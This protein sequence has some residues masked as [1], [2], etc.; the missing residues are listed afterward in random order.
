L[1]A[2][3]GMETPP[4]SEASAT[5]PSSDLQQL[6]DAYVRSL[7]EY[8]A[9]ANR[10]CELLTSIHSLPITVQEQ[11]VLVEQQRKENDAYRNYDSTRKRLFEAASGAVLFDASDWIATRKT[12]RKPTWGRRRV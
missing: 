12:H 6:S 8:F 4:Q 10:T 1:I 7:A 11:L 9:E 2:R 3:L 5:N